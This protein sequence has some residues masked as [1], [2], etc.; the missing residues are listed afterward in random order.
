MRPAPANKNSIVKIGWREDAAS[1]DRRSSGRL[2]RGR[3]CN[4]QVGNF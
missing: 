3:G 1:A 4:F 2:Q